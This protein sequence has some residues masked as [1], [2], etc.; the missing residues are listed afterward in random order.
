MLWTV[1]VPRSLHD[2]N[3]ETEVGRALLLQLAR[4]REVLDGRLKCCCGNTE[5]QKKRPR[6]RVATG[7]VQYRIGQLSGQP[8]RPLLRSL[9]V[10][11]RLMICVASPLAKAAFTE[12]TMS[13]N[14]MPY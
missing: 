9:S 5:S 13:V 8:P 11:A 4:A 6:W 1:F 3:L 10:V 7:V 12:L 2:G 14:D